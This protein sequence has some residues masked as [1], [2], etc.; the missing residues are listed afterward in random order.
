MM[1]DEASGGLDIMTILSARSLQC[2]CCLF[3]VN[4]SCLDCLLDCGV[5]RE[6]ISAAI[7]LQLVMV[8]CENS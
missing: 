6:F 1:T 5:I 2:V 4:P 7:S 3:S 8:A